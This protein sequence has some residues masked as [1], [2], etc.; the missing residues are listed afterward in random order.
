MSDFIHSAS[1]RRPPSEEHQV[2]FD[3]LGARCI[4][5]DGELIGLDFVESKDQV[6]Q[7]DRAY[8]LGLRDQLIAMF[9]PLLERMLATEHLSL[10]RYDSERGCLFSIGLIDEA[11]EQ[12]DNDIFPEPQRTITISYRENVRPE[13]PGD[14]LEYDIRFERRFKQSLERSMR[15]SQQPG[16]SQDRDQNSPQDLPE[17]AIDPLVFLEHEDDVPS[18]VLKDSPFAAVF[19]LEQDIAT[20]SIRVTFGLSKFDA[21]NHL[22]FHVPLDSD[23]LV[24]FKVRRESAL[25]RAELAPQHVRVVRHYAEILLPNIERCLAGD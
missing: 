16:L 5:A 2:L 11:L 12:L 9:E 8:I 19:R 25:T 10:E 23:G 1:F 13:L 18:Y 4:V 24:G 3:Q 7:L 21:E 20:S 15:E 22:N 14:R 17:L 6:T